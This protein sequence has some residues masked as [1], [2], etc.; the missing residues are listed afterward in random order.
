VHLPDLSDYRLVRTVSDAPIDGLTV[1]GLRVL[2]FDRV[3]RA[4]TATAGVY[5]FRCAE[6]FVAWGYARETHCRY[7][8][9][10]DR[11]GEWEPPLPGCPKVWLIPDGLRMLTRSGE[12]TLPAV[13]G[14]L[15]AGEG[16]RPSLVAI[17]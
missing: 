13:D 9:F 12:I 15:P 11:R 5:S 3:R 7:H 2:Y 16:D 6:I 1:P 4:G 14:S 8:A 10:R 17:G